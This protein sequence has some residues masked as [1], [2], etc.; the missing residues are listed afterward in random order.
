[1][2]V[3]ILLSWSIDSSLDN[4]LVFFKIFADESFVP[5][6]SENILCCPLKGFADDCNLSNLCSAAGLVNSSISLAMNS[7]MSKPFL[8]VASNISVISVG[9]A[10]VS[11]G[12]LCFGD[13]T[14][15]F[16]YTRRRLFDGR[17]SDVRC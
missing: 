3:L 12:V 8:E 4:S 1:M 10:F 13:L 5:G 17:D 6:N 16:K 9:H 7:L 14:G 15:F 2:N 11:A